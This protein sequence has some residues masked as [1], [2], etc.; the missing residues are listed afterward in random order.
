MAI[1]HL[2]V[3][4]HVVLPLQNPGLPGLV[5]LN[6]DERQALEIQVGWRA[7]RSCSE[8]LGV[9]G[10]GDVMK[11]AVFRRITTWIFLP[12]SIEIIFE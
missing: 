9:L 2:E 12:K 1:R 5:S 11:D 4:Q 7:G 3:H 6:D 8:D 10:C